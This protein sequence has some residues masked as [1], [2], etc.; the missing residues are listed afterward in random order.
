MIDRNSLPWSSFYTKPAISNLFERKKNKKIKPTSI[1]ILFG[2]LMLKYTQIDHRNLLTICRSSDSSIYFPSFRCFTI[3]SL[4]SSALLW[5]GDF[6]HWFFFCS[7]LI[8]I[9]LITFGLFWTFCLFV[10][11]FLHQF[12]SFFSRFKWFFFLQY[13]LFSSTI[14]SREVFQFSRILFQII[15]LI[16]YP[17]SK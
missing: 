13:F 10:W 1:S 8:V 7:A 9:L 11:F 6:F 14:D 15:S 12:C 4:L 2:I 17:F 16:F 5:L 3:L